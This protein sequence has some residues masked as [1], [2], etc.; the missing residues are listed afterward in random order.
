MMAPMLLKR[1]TE[2]SVPGRQDGAFL[3]RY[4]ASTKLHR[5]WSLKLVSLTRWLSRC[6]LQG[7]VVHSQDWYL[8]HTVCFDWP[9]TLGWPYAR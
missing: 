6:S 3:R 8:G 2:G 9:A 5:S 7:T 1:L 4:F